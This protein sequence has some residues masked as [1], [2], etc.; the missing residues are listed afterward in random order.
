[1]EAV[2]R[3][4][5][6]RPRGRCGGSREEGERTQGEGRELGSGGE[7]GVAVGGE[8]AAGRRGIPIR[9]ERMGRKERGKVRRRGRGRKK[10]RP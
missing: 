8:S 7:R 10:N 3:W 1:M 2:Q 4:R 5:W 6:R 9:R